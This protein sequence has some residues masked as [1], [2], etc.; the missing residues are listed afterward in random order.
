MTDPAQRERQSECVCGF[1]PRP[2]CP[3]H[4]KD[5]TMVILIR[6][7]KNK[8]FLGFASKEGS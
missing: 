3:L 4:G 2:K 6:L 1:N 5:G 7:D 8:R